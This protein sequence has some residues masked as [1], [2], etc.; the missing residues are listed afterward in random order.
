MLYLLN[1][2]VR[3]V[4]WNGESL[5]EATSAIVK[6]TMNGDFTLTVKYPISDSGI[7]QLIQE[8]ML[9]KAPTPVLGAQLFRIK[10]PVEHN[11]HLEITAYHISDDVMQRSI[12]QMSVTSQSCGMALSRMV[13]NTKTA[14]GDFSFNSDIQDRRTFNTTETE[15]LY[16]VLLDGKHSIVGTW[17]GE[18]VRDNFAMTVKKSRG[19][20]RGVVIT[21]HKNLKDYQRTKNSQNVVTRIHARSTFKPEGAEKETTIRVTVDSPL[22]NSYPY[23]NEKEYENNNAKSVEEL[24][25]WAQAKFSNE[26][27][28][29][30]SDAIKIEAYELDG[31]V[32]HMGDTVNLKSW[33]HNVDVFKKA[34][35]YEFDALKEEYISLILDDKA[36]AGGSRTS[37]GLSSAADAILGVTESAQEVALEKALQNADLDFDHKAGLL[38][39]E[40]SDGIELAKAK[41]EEVK[42]ELSDTINQRFNSFDNGPLK[43]AKR[44]AEEA[45]RNAGASSL[46]AQEAKRIG[47]DSVAR[48]EEFKSQ[49][50][51]AQTALSGDLDALKRT[52]VNDIRPKQAQVEAEIAKQVEAL[53]QTKK[54]LA[55]ASTLLAQEAKRIELDSVARL[56]AFKSQTTSAQTALSG[57]LDVLKRTIA[58][59]IRPKQAQAEAEIAKQVEA[60]SRTKNELSGA[61]TLLA[62]EAKRIEL[63]SVARLEAFK[64]Q[65]TSAQTALSGDLDVLK[66]TIANDIRPKQA[67]AEA[68]IAKQVEVLSRTKNELSG[69]KSAQATY[70]E[71][72]TRRLSELTNLANGKASKSELTQTAEELASRIASVQAGSS[73]N[74]F[75]NSRS[76][77]F[78]TGGQAVYDYRTFIVPDFWKNSDRFK[79]DYVRISF[80]VTFPVALVND[81][82]AMVHF[83]AHP[84]YA[85]RNLIFKGGTVERQHFEFTIDLSSSSEDYQ[86]NNVF[87][88]FGTNYGFPAGLQVVIENAMLSVG[89]YFPAYQPAYEDQEDR[90]SVVESNFKQRADSLDAGVSRLTE[91]LRTKADISSLNVTAENIR[92]SV[93]SLETDTQNK[94]NQKLSQAE[95]EVRAG[96]IRQ[97]ILNATKDKASKSELTQT[98]EELSSKIASVQ[99]SGRN[100]FLNSLFKQDISKT[101]IW[102]TSTYTA[103]IDSES[104]YL[105]YNA[106]K[107]IGLNPS[108]RDGGNPKVTYPALGQFGKV[109][110]GSTTNQ[111]VTISFYA[112]AN[113]NGIML[114]SRLGNIGYKTG[115]VTLSTEIKRYVVHIPK[116][117]T[118]ESKQTTNEWLFNFNQEGTVWIWMPK[119]EISDVDTSYS[120]APE[121]IEGQI[122]TVESTFKQRANSLE[123]GVSR[124]TEGLRTKADISS[125]NVTAE[126]IRQS[127]KSLETDTQNKLNQK[128]SQAEFEVRAGSIRQ[129]ILNATKDKA[130][131]SELTQTAEELASKIASVHLGRRNLLK[132]TK[133]LARYKPVSEYNGFKVIRTVAGATR[134]Q[135]S[136]VERTVIPTAG[137]EYIAIFYARASENDYPVRCHFYNPNTVVSSENSSGYKSRSSDGLSIIRLSTDWQLCWVKWT[138]T[139]TDQAKTVIIG[140]HGPQVGGKEGVWVEICAPAIFEGNLAGDW[141]PAYED[142]DERVS[143]VESN[144]KQ[145]ADSLEAGVSRLTEGLRTKA[146]ISSLNVTAENIRQ[147]VKSLETDT[148]NKLNQKLSQA[149]FE[150]R[151]GSIRQEILNATKDKASKSELT[152]T[153]EE[154]SSKIASVQVGGRNYIRGTKR[155]MLARGL[156][157]SGT[158]RPSGAGTA[159]TID[160]SDSPVTGFDKAIRL[161]SSNARDQIGIAQDGFYISQGTYT[162]SCWVKGR[163]GQ[164]VKLQTY[165][166]V[167]D[168]SGISPIFTLKDE[169]WTKLS[170]TSARN[171]AGVA[172][173]GYVYL[174]NAEVGEYLDVL[175][176][177]LE[178]GSL[179]TS[180][181][182]APEDIEGQIST[183]ES[184]FKQRANSLDAGVRSLTEGLRTKV[185]ISSLNVTAENIRQSVKRLETD[186]QNKLNQKLSQAEF[187]VRAGSIRQEILNATKDKAS[188]SELTQTAEELSSKIA[189]VQASGRNLFLNSLFKQDI[190][191][192]G[193]WTTS[194]YTAA[195]DSES[196]YLGYNALKIIGLNPSGRDG[197]NP[198][199]TYPALGQFGKV[200]PGSTTNQDVTISFYAKANKN[201][202]MLRSRLGNIGYKTGNVTLSTEIKRYVVHIPKGWTNESKQTTNEWLFNF[203]QEGTVWIWMPKFEISDV[204]TS[205]SEAPEDIEGQI[206]TVESTFKQ[207]ANSLEAG[208]NRLTE[209]LRT[210]VDISA[211]NVTAEN[212]RQS[213]KSLE[214]DTQNKLNQKLSQAEFEVRAGSI[215]QEI[216]NA[217]KDKASKSELTQTAEE[218]SSKIASV[219]VGGINLLRNTASLLIGDRSKGCWMSTSGGNGRAISVEVL[220]PPKKMIKNM[221]RVIENTNGGNKDLTQLVGLRIGEKYTISCYARIASDSPNANVNL[222]FR[223]WANN[224]DLNRKFQKSI[225][226]KN[227]Q[228]YSFTFTADAIENSIQFGQSGAGII[229]ICAPKIESGTLATDYSEAPEDIEGQIS[230]VESTFKQRANSLDAGV[231]RLTE[232]LR[233][234]VDISALNV[235][236]ENIRQSVKSLETDTQNKLNQKLSQAEFE[237]RAGSIRQEILNA[238]KDKADKT[239]VVSEAGK[240][241]EEF[242]KMKV[243]GRNLWIKSKTVGAVIEKLP[244]NHVTGQ[245]ECYRLENNS[246]LTFNLEPDFSSRLYQKVT[247]SAWIKYE[248]VV[249]GRNFWNVFN[250]FKH[251]LFRKNSETGVQSGPDY[252]TLGMYKGSADWKYITF[253]YDYSEKTNFD[254]LKTSLRFNLEGATSGTA[255]VTGIKVEIGSVAT[256]WSPAPEDADGLIT[257]AKAT[258]ERTA[259]GLRTDLSAIQEYVNKDGQ[260]QEALQRY[261]REESTRQAT[262]VRELVNRD[263]VGKATY[264]E[265]VKGINQ[266]IE[267]VKT[268]ANKDIASQIASYRQSVDGKF[269]DI[270][271]Q[272]TT[273]KQD[274]GGQISGLSNRLTSSEQGTTTQ[275]S[276]L[277]NRINSNKQGAD[278]QISNLKTQVATNKDNAERQ[279]GRISDQVSANKA[280]AD[281]QFANVTNQLARKVETTDFQRVKETSKLYERILG[282]TENGIADKVARMAL[283][284]QL[285]QVEVGKYSVSG[286]NLIKN[287]DFKNATNEWGSTQNLGRLVKHSFYHNGQKDLMRLSN[288]TKNENFLY[289][290]RFNLE[291]NTDYVL[292]FRGFNN[293]ALASYDVYILGRRAGESDGFTIVKKVVSSKKLSTSRCEDVSVTFNSGEMDNAYIRFDNNGSSSGTADLYITE[294]DLYKGYKPRTWQPHPEDAVADANKKLEATQTKM[295]QLAGS[296]VVENINS[297]GDIISGINLGANGHNRF[298]GKLTHITGETLIDRAVIK[299][300]MVDKLKTANFEAGSVT[301]T[302][303]DAEAVTAE[304]LKVDNALIRKLT[305]NDAFIDQLISKRIFSTKVESVISSSTFLE[306]YQGR[307]GGFTLGQFDQ[308]GGR[309]ISGV[310]QFSVGMGNGAGYGVRTAFW[311]N[312]GNNWNYAGPKAWNV[313]TDGK[314]YCRNEVGFYDQ[315][316][317]S[318]SSRANFYGNTTFS[319]SPVFSNGIELGSKDVLGDGWNPKG[320]R[321][322]VVWWNQVGSGSLKY[323]MEQKSDRRLKENIT[324]TAVKALD[325]INRLRMVAFDFIENKK[326]EEIGLIAQEAETIVPRIVSRDPENPDGYLHIDY[327]ALVPYLIKA[328][329]ELNQKIEK[330]EKIIA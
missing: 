175:A 213:V 289:S 88:R 56:E 35:A 189:S 112:K 193:I 183:V 40:I 210:K 306:A 226:H 204:D 89:N 132:G 8:D 48:L 223:S 274:V 3:T 125:L 69:V 298:V 109:I 51:S 50:T 120:E 139:A 12:T 164:K 96:S 84:W 308:G 37:G 79:R 146:D 194:T 176:P 211:L 241:R 261:T 27:I 326:H 127:V 319:R 208:V 330:M 269:T 198:K 259:Q 300:A 197:G 179:A 195:I 227:W 123:A 288:A 67:Q 203:N 42:Q 38:R 107:I 45:L 173:I 214:T 119:F 80:D 128:L 292:N 318:N 299:S 217:T 152:Q 218:L 104:K 285:F 243:G 66:R 280:N 236:A 248:N 267:A 206:L 276:N 54:E 157:A 291:R 229:E 29:K 108:G 2:D 277:S 166:Q 320:G 187:E 129:E 83:S 13:Q 170:F 63:D 153:A 181:K 221:I 59:D 161:T 222:L 52:I 138:Q 32:V 233:T 315:V 215:R 135:D 156:W 220:D 205:Y 22:I 90:V 293:S 279:M 202:I 87:I 240:L 242:S 16:S 99:A 158:F 49:T 21:T 6:E 290:H 105:G 163:R 251:Y 254:Q 297:A 19:E 312:W 192:T 118:N 150:V 258:F 281:S 307:I 283:T 324:D 86:T 328:I 93:K 323:W 231:S 39:Q 182:E 310:N 131:K 43:E 268:S 28:D 271:S 115:N 329:Q 136:Y 124:L 23:I 154:L 53:V 172:S 219:Q 126:N 200:I 321:N 284:N 76:R 174:V 149:E 225:S 5:H 188:K 55:G 4:R 313:N 144:F 294:V 92:Q 68:E 143:A 265:D 18:L 305:A 151:A 303:L 134:Y 141:S 230:T 100:L 191:K 270:S 24:Q 239:L 255:W 282:N 117:W 64:S 314:M 130:S 178:D 209:G 31:Q 74:Y 57:D 44:R 228:K 110:P 245:K 106:L 286:P 30:I 165:W 247:F 15:T 296:W 17:E 77:T 34:I 207:R 224:T 137:T 272:I 85:Y 216:L 322:A 122:S 171:R 302:I 275:I 121:D 60:L 201:G 25:K 98:A 133:E 162:M 257:E 61:S 73:R 140:R 316:D 232:G 102:T 287:S 234:K 20:N 95:F 169:N 252:A 311:A 196:K 212:I 186:T 116:G 71:T 160:V 9:I 11:D 26:G 78:T 238:T 237:V 70:E 33:K 145:R 147:S 184:T 168:N 111:D 14:L 253:T 309:W 301:T 7:Y 142:Q 185:D 295:T 246:T 235:T 82:P 75:R 256:D 148:Q 47:L 317:F 103:A 1:E 266:R 114:R 262:A 41:A 325:K 190:S 180:S 167:N 159:K 94:L 72:T 304:K 263:F 278:N 273:Y 260:R 46:L 101:G 91:G 97:E 113:K 36:G 177:Q 65:T 250:C 249:Q 199:V 81:M 264:Q 58:N 327:T 10:K 62:Q 244:E 155:M